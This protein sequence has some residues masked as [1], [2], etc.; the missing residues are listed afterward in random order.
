M[1]VIIEQENDDFYFDEVD[2]DADPKK[3]LFEL[4]ND[5]DNNRLALLNLLKI[6]YELKSKNLENKYDEMKQKYLIL[7]KIYLHGFC[8]MDHI[9]LPI[10][11]G[12]K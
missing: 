4:N 3:E 1:N 2:F 12:S 6:E 9:D 10:C 7:L 8:D 11:G 5:D